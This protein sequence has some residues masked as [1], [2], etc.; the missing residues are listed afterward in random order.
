[1]F[2]WYI[3]GIEMKK[4]TKLIYKNYIVKNSKLLDIE[5]DSTDWFDY[6]V[7]QGH[8]KFNLISLTTNKD[9]YKIFKSKKYYCIYGDNLYDKICHNFEENEYDLITLFK[10]IDNPS[11]FINEIYWLLKDEKYLLSIYDNVKDIRYNQFRID[12]QYKTNIIFKRYYK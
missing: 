4:L 8:N 6:M 10:I 5:P 3:K 12:K 11:R 7:S 2:I 9:I 1:M